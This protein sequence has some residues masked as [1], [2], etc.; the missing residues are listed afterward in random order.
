MCR[1]DASGVT[2]LGPETLNSKSQNLKFLEILG[3]G[4]NRVIACCK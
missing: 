4:Y 1:Q 2:I 3:V